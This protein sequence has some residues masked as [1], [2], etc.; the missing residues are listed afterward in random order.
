MNVGHQARQL[1]P[2]LKVNHQSPPGNRT[3]YYSY[4]HAL[5]ARQP[6]W[7]RAANCQ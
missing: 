1:D 7:V 6:Q 5:V 3:H 4:P 2:H